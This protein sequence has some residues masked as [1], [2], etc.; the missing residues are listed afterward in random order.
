MDMFEHAKTVVDGVYKWT[1]KDDKVEP[2][3]HKFPKEVKERI[4]YFWE[5]AEDGMT[6]KLGVLLVDVPE[7]KFWK[8]LYFDYSYG[9]YKS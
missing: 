3:V 6:E 9:I 1:V 4:D 8:Y 2:P 5:M 7:P